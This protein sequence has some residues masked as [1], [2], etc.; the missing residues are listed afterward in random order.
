MNYDQMA[1]LRKRRSRL[2]R[3]S[4]RGVLCE[5]QMWTG[6]YYGAECPFYATGYQPFNDIYIC[7]THARAYINVEP[8]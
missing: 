8:K 5:S 3:N 4:P 1:R 2:R 7:G 6:R